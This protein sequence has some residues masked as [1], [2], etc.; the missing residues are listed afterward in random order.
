[1]PDNA[2]RVRRLY[3]AAKR[4][5]FEAWLE[6]LHAGAEWHGADGR[7][8]FGPQAIIEALSGRVQQ[9]DGF[10]IDIRR[11]ISAGDTVVVEARYRAVAKASG[12]VLDAPVAHVFDLRDGKIIRVRQYTDSWHVTE[13]ADT[14]P[15]A[16]MVAT[17]AGTP[18]VSAK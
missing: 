9:L 15:A 2:E 1:M 18:S 13:R 16:G 3:E 14:S 4:R 11:I 17:G 8:Y 6:L 5:D 7:T 12:R 10:A